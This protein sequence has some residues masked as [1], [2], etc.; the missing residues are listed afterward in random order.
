MMMMCK[1]C[2][3]I[4]NLMFVSLLSECKFSP[5]HVSI[6][7]IYQCTFLGHSDHIFIRSVQVYIFFTDN[8][9]R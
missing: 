7:I 3:S 8:M 2:I 1:K 5:S 4:I 6:T 9:G